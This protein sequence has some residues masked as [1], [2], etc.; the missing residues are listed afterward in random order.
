MTL[1]AEHSV[2]TTRLDDINGI[3][4]IDFIKLDVQGSELT[5]LSNAKRLLESCLL[6]QVEVE[7][8]ELY[9]GQPLF[10]DVDNFMRSRCFQFHY[11]VGHGFAGR[12]FK[13]LVTDDEFNKPVNQ[14]L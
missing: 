11:F 8:V 7:F 2:A 1:V 13:P 4:K 14:V 10:S 5:I 12:T 3:E 6:V 9:E